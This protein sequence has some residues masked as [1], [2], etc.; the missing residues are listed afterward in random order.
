MNFSPSPGLIFHI[1]AG[2]I[3]MAF[4]I[5]ALLFRKGSPRHRLAG[6][7]F[8]LAM[9]G[10]TASGAVMAYLKDIP[11]SVVGGLFALYL[12]ASAWMTVKRK[13]GEVGAFEKIA[14]L[15][16]LAIALGAFTL[17]AGAG[18][19]EAAVKANASA[20]GY[21]GIG[22]LVAL[23]VAFD[24]RMIVQGGVR[25]ARRIVRHL[26]RMCFAL[27]V[28][29]GSLFLG[30]QKFFPEAVRES[31][32]LYAPVVLVLVLWLFWFVRVRFTKWYER[33]QT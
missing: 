30:Q 9:L 8:V 4:G 1:A 11:S 6:N 33:T 28:A 20:N 24:V 7:A 21:I 27:L 22:I 10:L 17:A 13:E 32:V 12:V 29:T 26:G 25:G 15:F 14:A 5:A 19:D 3:G 18:S 2:T 23:A 16:G 31:G